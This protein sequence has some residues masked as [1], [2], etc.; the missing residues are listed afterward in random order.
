[1]K[2]PGVSKE[3]NKGGNRR[4]DGLRFSKKGE[5]YRSCGA[6]R[7]LIQRIPRHDPGCSQHCSSDPDPSIT[8]TMQ[9]P[10]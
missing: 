7:T 6:C 8:R 9:T 1:M 4:G 10:T 2:K 3:G 5:S